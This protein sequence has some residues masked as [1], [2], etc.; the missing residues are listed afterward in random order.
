[1]GRRAAAAA[2]DSAIVVSSSGGS[3]GPL[4]KALIRSVARNLRMR[5]RYQNE[6]NL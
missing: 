6:I 3:T 4:K 1:M 2:E 5:I